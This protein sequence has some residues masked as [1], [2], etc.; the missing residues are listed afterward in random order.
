LLAEPSAP[1]HVWV[2]LE[3][4]SGGTRVGIVTESGLALESLVGDPLL[5]GADVLA[6][7]A[8]KLLVSRSR[9]RAVE[10]AVLECKPSP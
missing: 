9:G 5:R 4:A 3:S 8:G 7:G 2:A 10:L 1:G 6:A